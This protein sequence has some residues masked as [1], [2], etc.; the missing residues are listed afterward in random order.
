MAERGILPK[1]I[2]DCQ[3]PF[4]QECSYGKMTRRPWQSKPSQ[5][6]SVPT[7]VDKPWMVVS[8]DQLESP[9][10]GFIAQM[11]G[12]LTRQRYRAAT[13]F[14]DHF[15][16]LSYVH[17]QQSTSARE[18]LQAKIAFEAYAAS[19]GVKIDKYHAD[20]GR[21]ADDVTTRCNRYH[22]LG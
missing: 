18:I 12:K 9:V 16:S 5:N 6:K 14:V 15:S 20:N 17:L 3:T 10:P 13:I 2:I 11:K 4:S 7:P 19:C 21:F 1:K 8:V 22:S